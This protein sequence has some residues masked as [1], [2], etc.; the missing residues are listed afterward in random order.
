[1]SSLRNISLN[2]KKDEH[3]TLYLV[4]T[5]FTLSS[6]SF[7]LRN[8]IVN[9][10]NS[11]A[12]PIQCCWLRLIDV[13]F[14]NNSFAKNIFLFFLK[15]YYRTQSAKGIRKTRPVGNVRRMQ[16]VCVKSIPSLKTWTT[17]YSYIREQNH[18]FLRI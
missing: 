3:Y 13:W 8:L 17:Y 6:E 5:V 16:K 7:F 12:R 11:K 15:Q 2:L 14:D 9:F 18:T 10:I 4:S 1:M